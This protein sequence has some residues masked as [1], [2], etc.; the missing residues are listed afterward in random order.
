MLS[1]RTVR[2]HILQVANDLYLHTISDRHMKESLGKFHLRLSVSDIRRQYEYLSRIEGE[3]LSAVL[4]VQKLEE[5]D[6]WTAR[7][8]SSGVDLL[9]GAANVNG[10]RSGDPVVENLPLKKDIRRGILA[11][12]NEKPGEFMEDVDL[13]EQFIEDGFFHVDLPEIQYQLW[14]LSGKGAIEMKTI[15]IGSASN[16]TAKISSK[17][18]DILAGD[19]FDI[20]VS[21]R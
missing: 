11:H 7:I 10:V 6:M 14:Y 15:R 20:G 3:K 1:L 19:E 18:C 16:Y 13:V 21:H 12:L 8:T 5:H 9:T 17:G 2:R 4:N